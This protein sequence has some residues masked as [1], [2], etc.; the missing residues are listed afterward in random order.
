MHK[1][2]FRVGYSDISPNGVMRFGRL[3]DHFQDC[4]N[5]Q[6]QSQGLDLEYFKSIAQTWLA[7]SW[8]LVIKRMPVIYENVTAATSVYDCKSVFG[9]RNY[10]LYDEKGNVCVAGNSIGV[11]IDMATG[12]LIRVPKEEIKKY[13][14]EPK[15]DMEYLL[16]R[17][18]I[19]ENGEEKEHF[20]ITKRY[21]DTNNHVNNA[22]YVYMS[23]EYLPEDFEAR[24]LRVE[25]KNAAKH[26]N[27]VIPIIY[28]Q[29][30]LIIVTLC[31]ENKKPYA[32]IE[33]G[34]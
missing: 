29:E 13:N 3:I 17:I 16:F 15:L 31:D 11:Y 6:L 7:C 26:G 2:D 27:I 12:K 28:R 32:I 8:Q 9:Y 1:L 24:T 25:Y 22:Q 33:Y 18:D 21:L 20:I 14:I 4:Y 34:K 10:M 19:P 30:N 23:E 5:F